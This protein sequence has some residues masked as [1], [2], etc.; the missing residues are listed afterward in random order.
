MMANT[1]TDLLELILR[2]CAASSPQPWYPSA[3]VQATG[4]PR[5][6]LDASLDQLR[7]GGLIRLTDWVQGHGQGYVV[8]AEG[9]EVVQNPRLLGRLRAGVPVRPAAATLV[10]AS[11]P[12]DRPTTWE[13]GEAV[14][15][16]LLDHSRS[17]VTMALIFLNVLV[18]LAGLVLAVQ[19]HV[20]VNEYVGF[21]STNRKVAEI[22][23]LTGGLF[24]GDVL[25]KGQWWRLLSYCFVHGGLLHLIINMYFL[26]SVGPMVERM[27]GPWRYLLLY[28]IA[29][30]GGG[31]AVLLAGSAAVGASGALC[32]LLAAMAV[33]VV[34]N[35]RHLP[36]ALAS[37][38]LRNIM[39]NV[40]LIV[41]I[42][43][44]PGVSA[45]G[46]FGGGIVGLIT[47]VPL[48]LNR[49]GHGW[50]RWLGAAGVAVIPL[51]LIG[52]VEHY[53]G[54]ERE[55][56]QFRSQTIPAIAPAYDKEIKVFKD[57]AEPLLTRGPAGR[58][59][60]PDAPEARKEVNEVRKLM[61][62]AAALLK[63][64]GGFRNPVVAAKMD[65]VRAYV[66]AASQFYDAL[67]RAL[68]PKV[69][70]TDGDENG[71]RQL[72]GQL[73]SRRQELIARLKAGGA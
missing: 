52:V 9:A 62:D 22:R 1:S 16:A 64:A 33:W 14:R 58:R 26:Y 38:W 66:D 67:G 13:R 8:T 19:W 54:P 49:F 3:Y 28:L 32:G 50:Q 17:T 34:M 10:P 6:G 30:F 41:I 70:W 7:L 57:Y 12:S 69:T 25:A 44:M 65:A 53:V 55:L 46:H 2:E 23:D 5:D 56:A 71:L 39:V 31:C 68:D 45:A 42:S 21:S 37:N 40:V 60:D 48:T 29:G 35:R 73:V 11:R 4:V 43:M 36:T 24:P 59:D 72:Q 63:A 51:A 47:A 18:F 61:Q 20:P 27:L 15:T